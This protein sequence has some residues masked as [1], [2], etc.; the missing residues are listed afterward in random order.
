MNIKVPSVGLDTGY[1]AIKSKS[2]YDL[3]VTV[4]SPD[5]DFTSV[6]IEKADLLHASTEILKELIK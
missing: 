1:L 2:K 6:T 5:G 3:T 4:Y